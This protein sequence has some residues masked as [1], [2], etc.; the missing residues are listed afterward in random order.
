[1]NCLGTSNTGS[2][3]CCNAN[4]LCSFNGNLEDV[5][6][7]PIYV[8]S[9]YDAVRF[10]MNG[11]KTVQNL[12]FTPALPCGC[13]ISRV[14]EIRCKKIFDPSQAKDCDNLTI[15]METGISG[16]TFLNDC[17]G[18]WKP[19]DLTESR[20]KKSSSR[21]HHTVMKKDAVR[22]S[23]VH[24]MSGCGETSLFIW[25]FASATAAGGK[26]T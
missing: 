24:R 2:G 8:Q 7:T 22:R 5:V 9:V 23:S 17:R 19:S 18:S 13:T 1:M 11:M 12:R 26:A 25:I 20:R 14:K 10:H 21:T 15:D 16:A 3:G 4:T 6:S